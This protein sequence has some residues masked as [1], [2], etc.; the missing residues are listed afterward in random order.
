MNITEPTL[1]EFI[2]IYEEEFGERL[3]VDEAREVAS[4]LI[5]LYLILL[6]PTPS[7]QKALD[8]MEKKEK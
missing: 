1:H 2:G 5:D 3:S 6:S 4:N 7:E 8:D